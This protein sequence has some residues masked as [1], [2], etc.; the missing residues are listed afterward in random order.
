MNPLESWLISK[1]IQNSAAYYIFG[2]GLAIGNPST[3]RFGLRMASFGGRAA[4]NWYRGALLGRGPG[5]LGTTM[6]RGG[7]M[8]LGRAAVVGGYTTA[9]VAAIVGAG[10]GVSHIIGKEMGY[11]DA[12]SDYVDFMTG[13]VSMQDYWDAITLKSM[14]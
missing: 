11:E 10:Y 8:T 1:S 9:G 4:A 12:T 2:T 5:L 6:V 7:T 14:R 3:R 13:Q